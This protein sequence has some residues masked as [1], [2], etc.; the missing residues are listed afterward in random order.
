MK[1]VGKDEEVV[2][3]CS[4]SDCDSSALACAKALSLG[5]EKVYYFAEGYPGW[6]SAG[7]PI[8]KAE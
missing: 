4:G 3:Y 5:Y 8:E 2:F 6:E 7:Y 1:I